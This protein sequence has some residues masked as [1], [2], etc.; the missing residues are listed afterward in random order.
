M[1]FNYPKLSVNFFFQIT[2]YSSKHFVDKKSIPHKTSF[3]KELLF[4]KQSFKMSVL[5]KP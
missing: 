4:K 2:E 1:G 5:E 3:L